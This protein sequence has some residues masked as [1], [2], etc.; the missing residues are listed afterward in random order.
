[1][2]RIVRQVGMDLCGTIVSLDGVYVRIPTKA[3]TYSK[4]MA[5]T[6]PT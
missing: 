1:V 3:A 5:A 4:L 2:M 6:I